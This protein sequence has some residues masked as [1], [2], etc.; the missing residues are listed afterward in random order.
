MPSYEALAAQGIS[1]DPGG[2]RVF[3]AQRAKTFYSVLGAVFDTANLRRFPPVLSDAEDTND[4]AN[5][6]GVNRFSGFNV[7]TIAIEVPIT[8]VTQDQKP[9]STENSMIGMYASTSPQRTTIRRGAPLSVRDG[10][11]DADD[12]LGRGKGSFVPV[13]RMANPLVN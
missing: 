9:P 10:D 3:A 8:R 1:S 11:D 5:P 12:T 4:G 6:F 13:S 2:S 7:H